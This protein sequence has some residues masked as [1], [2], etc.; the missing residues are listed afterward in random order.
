MYVHAGD[1]LGAVAL[2][3][4]KVEEKGLNRDLW[5]QSEWIGQDGGG[6]AILGH[7]GAFIVGVH[8]KLLDHDYI[9][10]KGGMTTLGAISLR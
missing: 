5:Y 10:R 4:M 3:Y 8:S 1:L 2:T 6:S 9:T 7:N